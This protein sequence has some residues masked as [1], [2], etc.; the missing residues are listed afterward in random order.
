MRRQAKRL[1][2]PYPPVAPI[3]DI[4]LTLFE[5]DWQTA[6]DFARK[7]IIETMERA[8]AAS[9]VLCTKPAPKSVSIPTIKK[10]VGAGRLA[11]AM[12]LETDSAIEVRI[13]LAAST[14]QP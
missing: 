14:I 7:G 5:V 9:W 6:Y 11:G 10:K 8:P 1:Q 12:V 3:P 13:L 4:G 2:K